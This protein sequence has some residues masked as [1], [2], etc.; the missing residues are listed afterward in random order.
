[1][2][3]TIAIVRGGEDSALL[4]FGAAEARVSAAGVDLGERQLDWPGEY[5]FGGLSVECVEQ[6]EGN[7]RAALLA[8]PGR[9]RV[10]VL[11][12]GPSWEAAQELLARAEILVLFPHEEAKKLVDTL[13][14]RAAVFI[15]E[16]PAG[17]TAEESEGA[18]IELA[19]ADFPAD[20]T[21]VIK[22]V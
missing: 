4:R 18:E 13:E 14:P 5:E 11:A 17:V 22:I 21:R 15:G 3:E 7:A 2:S 6:A 8:A 12:G 16:A 9:P 20:A 10:G 19:A 1:M